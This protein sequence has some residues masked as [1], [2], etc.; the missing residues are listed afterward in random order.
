MAAAAEDGDCSG[1]EDEAGGCEGGIDLGGGCR[2]EGE[3]EGGGCAGEDVGSREIEVD[4]GI[5]CVDNRVRANDKGRWDDACDGG[6]RVEF[7]AGDVVGST[8][9]K[10]DRVDLKTRVR[11]SVNFAVVEAEIDCGWCEVSVETNNTHVWDAGKAVH[12]RSATKQEIGWAVDGNAVE[13][14]REVGMGG[15]CKSEQASDCEETHG[16]LL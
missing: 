3:V 14:W 4:V 13:T 10:I 1:E 8:P 7:E 16:K 11:R 6:S 12:Q 15:D 5:G 9:S 2:G